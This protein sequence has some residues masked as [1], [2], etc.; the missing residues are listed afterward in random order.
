[1]KA[2][3]LWFLE[4][5]MLRTGSILAGVTL[6]I[7]LSIWAYLPWWEL[8]LRSDKSPVSWLSSTLLFACAALAL[9]LGAQGGL[10]KIFSVLLTFAM[11]LLSLDEQ[12]QFHE[13][14]KYHCAD[15]VSWCGYPVQG[16]IDWLGDSPMALVGFIGLTTFVMLYRRIHT[17]VAKNLIIASITV[18][19][20]LA[21][22]THFGH[23]VGLLPAWFNRFEEVFEVFSESLFLCALIEMRVLPDAQNKDQVQ[24]ASS[25]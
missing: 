11:L 2:Q 23:A 25:L 5:W 15:W 13:Y 6:F 7:L 9:Q 10:S 18:G 1:M 24:S 21:L 4:A 16:H 19:V 14:W 3:A 20:V 8:A 22:G 17:T 12:F